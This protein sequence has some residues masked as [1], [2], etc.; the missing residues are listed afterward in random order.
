MDCYWENLYNLSPLIPGWYH[1]ERLCD[2]TLGWFPA[3][4]TEE[5]LNEHVRARNLRQ[6][7]RLLAASQHLIG[8]TLRIW[9]L[10]FF[11]DIVMTISIK[12]KVYILV[13]LNSVNT[14]KFMFLKARHILVEI[15]LQ[16]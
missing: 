13:L 10:D 12:F 16:T 11:R 1:G 9:S 6:R 2:G 14:Y 7:Y 4:H 5:I 8:G 3:N 15:F